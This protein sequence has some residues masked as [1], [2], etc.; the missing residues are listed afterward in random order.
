MEWGYPEFAVEPFSCFFGL[1]F[2]TSEKVPQITPKWTQTGTF[3]SYVGVFF[4]AFS[5]F[6]GKRAT[7][8][9]CAPARTDRMSSDP[10]EDHFRDFLSNIVGPRIQLYFFCFL[11]DFLSPK[12]TLLTSNWRGGSICSLFCA[13]AALGPRM[14]PR[15]AKTTPRPPK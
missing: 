9:P 5:D 11:Y 8:D 15:D 2:S 14:T 7:C 3:G 1:W 6:S 10:P 13:L 4:L 12:V